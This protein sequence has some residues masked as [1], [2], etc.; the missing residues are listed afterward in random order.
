MPSHPPPEGL[1][2]LAEEVTSGSCSELAGGLG[3]EVG[4]LWQ[5]TRMSSVALRAAVCPVSL[6]TVVRRKLPRVE[7]VP[8]LVPVTSCLK[9]DEQGFSLGA[10]SGS[11]PSLFT[12]SIILGKLREINRTPHLPR[13]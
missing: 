12:P 4:P 10:G 1:G 5:G 8:S 13:R 3:K 6:V 7:L 9:V 2:Q 11:R